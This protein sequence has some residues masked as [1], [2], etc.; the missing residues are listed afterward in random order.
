MSK[1]PVPIAVGDTE[2]TVLMRILS[3]LDL[4]GP[5]PVDELID[6]LRLYQH[7]AAEKI[8]RMAIGDGMIEAADIGGRLKINQFGL[9]VD[10]KMRSS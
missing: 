10:R 3:T 7:P 8:L 5:K 2:E 9:D 4:L 1:I 6:E